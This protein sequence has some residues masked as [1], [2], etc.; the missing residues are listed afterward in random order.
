M[1]KSAKMF[2]AL[3]GKWWWVVAVDVGAS[4]LGL[5]EVFG[6]RVPNW[7][8][9]VL[10]NTG[11]LLAAF[12]AFHRLRLQH[13][14]D[15]QA[16][17]TRTDGAEAKLADRLSAQKRQYELGLVLGEGCDILREKLAT[18]DQVPKY[19]E[20]VLA[21]KQHAAKT[22]EALCGSG[23]AVAFMHVHIL[24]AHMVGS[25]NEEHNTCRLHLSA[26]CDNLKN[27]I[28]QATNSA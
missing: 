26:L 15:V 17:N 14:H 2:A 7:V 28:D 10:L 20:R 11:L 13:E 22:I 3:V 6:R 24:A 23:K 8:W 4:G 5:A 9:F 18:P 12:L 1:W 21:W 16:A 19:K 25:I 27:L